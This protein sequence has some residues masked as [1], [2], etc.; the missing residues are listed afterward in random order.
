MANIRFALRMLLKTP[1]VT[2]VAVASL[3]L[4][5]GSNAAIFSLFNQ[6]LLRPLPV[7][8]PERLVNLEAPGP[9]PG[10]DSCNQAGDCDEVFSYPMFRDLQREQ[11]VF[12]DL[13]AHRTFG[14]N[15]AYRDKTISGEGVQVSGSYF[16]ALGLV[17]AL[18]RLLGPEVDE[19]I[20]GH[21]VTVL[22]HEFWRSHLGADPDVLG[23]KITINGQPLSVV[24]VA[25]AGFRGTTLGV[26]PMVFVPITMR[27]ALSRGFDGFEDRRDYW[28]YLF[29]RLKPDVSIEQARAALVPLYRGILAEVEAPLQVNM[30][31][32]TMARFVS[33]PIPVR[34][35]PA[36]AE[37]D[38]RGGRRAADPALR[39]HRHHR[40]DRL[41]QHRQPAP[42]AV[43]G[44]GPGDGGAA[45]HRRLPEAAPDAATDRVL[46]AGARRAGSPGSWSRAGRWD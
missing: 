41:R 31:E 6:V 16:P 7:V 2:G 42:G 26:R 40:P 44:A 15:V 32:Q 46:P 12:S 19:P 18:G 23:R 9:K 45:L 20:G 22:S 27:A 37:L 38:G 36:R 24:G 8:E 14:I 11:T 35:R 21:P 3:A 25:P 4:G 28:V 43:R 34:G 39:R 30:S 1:V 17:P 13:A 33:K 5:I 10:S 29:A